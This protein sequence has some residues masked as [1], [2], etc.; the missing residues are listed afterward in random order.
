[1]EEYIITRDLHILN[2]EMGIPS[3]ET[4]RGH[5]WIDLTLRNSKLA[6]NTKRWTCG[7]E[8]SCV[9]HKRIFFDIESTGDVGNT[10]QYFRKQYKP[11]IDNW[12]TFDYNLAQNMVKNFECGAN[13]YSLKECD[14]ELSQKVK[15]CTD[16]RG[17]IQ[18]YLGYN[19]SLRSI[20]SGA[21][22]R[23]TRI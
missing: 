6:Q 1:M 22:T 13:P 23:Q 3:F 10:T 11:K 4:N 14:I 20:V 15:L 8:E 17:H 18:I 5:S 16:R 2:T 21:K 7:E 19:R 9:D 12:G